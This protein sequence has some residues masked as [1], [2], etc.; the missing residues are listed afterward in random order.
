[1]QFPIAA[2]RRADGSSPSTWSKRLRPPGAVLYSSREPS[3]LSQ[4]LCQDDSTINVVIGSTLTKYYS[5]W[6]TSDLVIVKTKRV[7]VFETHSIVAVIVVFDIRILTRYTTNWS[8]R[9]TRLEW[10]S[11]FSTECHSIAHCDHIWT[12]I[13]RCL[14]KLRYF[15]IL[16]VHVYQRYGVRRLT[17]GVRERGLNEWIRPFI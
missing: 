14:N 9:G 16:V 7:N 17:S 1:M 4:W 11:I 10:S 6:P 5:N 3:E 15:V 8:G 12:F 13:H 2:Y